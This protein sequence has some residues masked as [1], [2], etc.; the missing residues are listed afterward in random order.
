M[1]RASATLLAVLAPL[2]CASLHAQ[3]LG[4]AAPGTSSTDTGVPGTS[5][6]G[7]TETS[8]PVRLLRNWYDTIKTP[9]GEI[10]RRV[11]ILYDYSNAA[12]IERWYTLD[13]RAFFNRKFTVNPPTPSE[14]EIAE[15][16]DI[17][18]K[19]K[20]LSII[21]KHFSAVLDGAFLIE[22]GRGKA[23]GPGARCLLVQILS[24]DH[25]GMIRVVGVDLVKQNIPYRAFIPSEHP[26]VK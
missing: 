26:G 4:T 18:K 25:S 11:D 22:E 8:R 6:S 16:F 1:R 24:P 10:A 23:C 14:A 13:G 17:V 21:I 19:D 5:N 2:F 12:A 15:A 3:V 9:N 20:E 7:I